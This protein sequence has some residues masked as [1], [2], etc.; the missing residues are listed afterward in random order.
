MKW[1]PYTKKND[2]VDGERRSIRYLALLPVFCE[3][4]GMWVWLEKVWADQIYETRDTGYGL[5][6]GW[7]TY[8]Y[9]K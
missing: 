4:I 1:T 2:P 6:Y 7:R 9:T 8:R 3:D 5:N